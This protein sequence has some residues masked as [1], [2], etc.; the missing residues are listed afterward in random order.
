[1]GRFLAARRA[2][3]LAA[4]RKY[5]GQRARG[6]FA[7]LGIESQVSKGTRPGA[8]VFYLVSWSSDLACQENL[9]CQGRR[10][11]VSAPHEPSQYSA[12][13]SRKRIKLRQ[14]TLSSCNPLTPAL[15]SHPS[16][17]SLAL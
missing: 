11:G 14:D 16:A 8:P 13:L 6:G 7:E 17:R 4:R 15:I 12:G 1:M 2:T 9:D 3:G 5:R 10:T